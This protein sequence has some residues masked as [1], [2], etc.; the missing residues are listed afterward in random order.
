MHP[1]NFIGANKIVGPP[2]G[3]LEAQVASIPAYVGK[4]K[5][6]PFDG[7]QFVVVAWVP[8]PEDLERIKSGMPIYLTMLG[9]LMPHFMSTPS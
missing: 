1:T 8:S 6:G 2:P 4:H 9:G 7:T 3:V 5:H